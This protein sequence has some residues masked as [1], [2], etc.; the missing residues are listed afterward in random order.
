MAAP[1]F[2][3]FASTPAEP[4]VYSFYK[5]AYLA[6]RENGNAGVPGGP[7][8][9]KIRPGSITP[10]YVILHLISPTTARYTVIYGYKSCSRTTRLIVSESASND[11]PSEITIDTS[12]IP[13]QKIGQEAS[14]QP[15]QRLEP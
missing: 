12:P 4:A 13:P 1:F 15:K 14:D 7:P 5:H 6:P 8:S 10:R 9:R 3:G 2:L 11:P